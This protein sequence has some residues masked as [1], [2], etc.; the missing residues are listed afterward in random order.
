MSE[1]IHNARQDRP[2]ESESYDRMNRGPFIDNLIRALI[3]DEQDE[4]GTRVGRR[5]TGYVIGLSGRWGSGKSSILNLLHHKLDKMEDVVVASFN[6]WI[7][8]G[9]DELVVGF[10]NSLRSALG[11][12]SSEKVRDTVKWIDRYWGALKFAGHGVAAAADL[13]GAGGVATAAFA[14]AEPMLKGSIVTG[15]PRSPDQEKIILEQKIDEANFAVVVLIDELDRIEDDEVRAVAQLVKAVGE[16]KG[17]SY[18]VAFDVERVVQALGRGQDDAKRV[19][20]ERYLEKI[21]QHTIPL[22][23]LFSEDVH[24]LLQFSLKNY[25]VELQKPEEEMDIKIFDCIVDAIETPR[26]VKR[27]IGSYSVIWRMVANEINPYDVLAYCWIMTKSFQL[28]D[29]IAENIEDLIS[30]PGLTKMTEAVIRRMN[31]DDDLNLEKLLGSQALQHQKLLQVIFPSLFRMSSTAEGARISRRRNLVRLLYLGNPPGAPSRSEIEVIWREKNAD[32]LEAVIRQMINQNK[33][34]A[35]LDRL[36]DLARELPKDG[37]STFWA[38][39]SKALTRASDWLSG[40]EVERGFGEDVGTT[41]FRQAQRDPT[42]VPRFKEILN[43]LIEIDDIAISPWIIMK[44]IFALGLMVPNSDG[45]GGEILSRGYAEPLVESEL[46]RYRKAILSGR[47]LRRSPRPDALVCLGVTNSIGAE[48]RD[49]LTDQ[50]NSPEAIWTLAGLLVPPGHMVDKSFLELLFD[51][52]IVADRMQEM[53][54]RNRYPGNPWLAS[55]VRRLEAILSDQNPD[56][57]SLI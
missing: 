38:G 36:D 5:A 50:L 46:E 15:T 53:S 31:K 2:I 33:L 41:L 47:L 17:L 9:R 56:G 32:I 11:R 43:K 20:G 13:F 39:M 16:I 24:E 34:G 3:V 42:Q 52:N 45:K 7:F 51:I 27:L 25:G 29:K 6:P 44:H 19:S 48:V 1:K 30:D 21:I 12:S 8:K 40:P 23:P 18:L 4:R 28:R 14:K 37:D 54:D 10:F 57:F 35:I 49:S 22:R 55:S 26:D